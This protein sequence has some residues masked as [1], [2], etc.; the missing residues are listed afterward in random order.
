MRRQKPDIPVSQHHMATTSRIR[1]VCRRRRRRR[2]RRAGRQ[3][4]VPR[5]IQ[6]ATEKPRWPQSHRLERLFEAA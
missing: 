3:Q 5:L 1:T 2:P 4:H 6:Q